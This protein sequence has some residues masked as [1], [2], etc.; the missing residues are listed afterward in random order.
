MADRQHASILDVA[1]RA[2]VSPA[3]VS[4]ALRGLPHV[5]EE[6]RRR[7]RQ[8]AQDLNYVAS[9][10]GTG[11]ASGRTMTV[12]LVVPLGARWFFAHIIAAAEGV[13]QANGY[14][15]T[16]YNLNEDARRRHFFEHLPSRRKVDG[17]IV[18]ALPLGEDEADRLH[19]L[20]VPIVLANIHHD[21]FPCVRIDD[22]A[23]ARLAGQHLADLG[24]ESACMISALED[25]DAGFA[26]G[27]LRR[28]GFNDAL[29]L[30]GLD[31]H[32]VAGAWGVEGGARAMRSL[33]ARATRPTAVFAEYDELAFGALMA[34]REEGLSVPGDVSV[35]GFDDHD[36][37]RV[38]DLTTVRQP[39]AEQGAL[40]AE[41]LLAMLRGEDIGRG[42]I[43]LPTELVVRGS[44]AAPRCHGDDGRRPGS[45]SVTL[46]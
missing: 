30:S 39:V 14:D 45:G 42:H 33:L 3:T 13:L 18:A 41:R 20:R 34:L 15:V 46:R 32:A 35:V 44:T 12:G 5:S 27:P 23:G 38:V 40:A 26:G 8:A 31:R 21:E 29:G 22:R 7:V 37:A 25:A 1:A 11:L 6:T 16:L 10:A 24:H 17:L 28:A 43:V 9:P 4:R 36:L 2:R 19:S